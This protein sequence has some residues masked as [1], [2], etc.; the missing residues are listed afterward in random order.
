[1]IESIR[2]TGGMSTDYISLMR[3]NIFKALDT[4]G[5]GKLDKSEL[6]DALGG[7]SQDNADSSNLISLL[8]SDGDGTIS[9]L[10]LEAGMS[11][12]HQDLKS[13]D[14]DGDLFKK[15]DTNGDG[16]VNKDEFIS[17]R[18]MEVSEEDASR[19]WS[20]LDTE[21]SGSLTESQFAAAMGKM[22]PPAGPPPAGSQDPSG[23]TSSLTVS[24]ISSNDNSEQTDSSSSTSVDSVLNQLLRTAVEKYM[25]G[26]SSY[27]AQSNGLTAYA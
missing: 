23:Q 2:F 26:G 18:P 5:D 12:L 4:S 14:N 16:T 22:G 1:M 25:Q 13:V 21:G 3:Q 24:G 15:I 19:M 17:N 10:E 11:K 27:L 20:A 8:D 6:S 7:S 9:E